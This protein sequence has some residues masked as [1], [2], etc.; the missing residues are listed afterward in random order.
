MVL[1]RSVRT[2]E[3]WAQLGILTRVKYGGATLYRLGECQQIVRH[4]AF[5]AKSA[6]PG[7]EMS[8]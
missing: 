3:R 5:L 4:G 8:R 1:R 6:V 7:Q 2:V